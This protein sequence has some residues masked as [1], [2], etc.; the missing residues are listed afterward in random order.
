MPHPLLRLPR[1]LDASAHAGVV[2]VE[3][4]ETA[5]VETPA[6][7]R[8][9]RA[10][11]AVETHRR[12][13]ETLRLPRWLDASAHRWTL[14]VVAPFCSLRLPRWLDASAHARETSVTTLGT[15]LRLPRWLDASAH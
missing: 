13:P 15:P 9:Q 1:W 11:R 8:R 14:H 2:A 4:V 6:L 7:A 3:A 5:G 12:K 10:R